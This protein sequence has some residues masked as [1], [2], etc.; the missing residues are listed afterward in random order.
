MPFDSSKGT[1]AISLT[2]DDSTNVRLAS[3]I[4]AIAESTM[5]RYIVEN[6]IPPHLT[7]GAFHADA[8]EVPRLLQMTESFSKTIFKRSIQIVETGDF[9]GKV[10]FARPLLDSYLTEINESLHSMLLPMFE[11][12][13]NGYYLPGNWF[14]HCTLA[15]KLNKKQFAAAKKISQE[16]VFPFTAEVNELSVY[17]C[18]P[19]AEIS[20]FE[21]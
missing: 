7:V 18:H 11:S 8:L 6:H 19:F 14:P 3:V 1:F 10:L 5:N 13:D 15:T 21:L 17:Q 20:R 9:L 16:I 4:S 2:F 12:G